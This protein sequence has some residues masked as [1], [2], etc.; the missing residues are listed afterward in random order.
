MQIGTMNRKLRPLVAS[1]A[2]ARLLEDE[3]AEAV[4]EAELACF[5]CERRKTLLQAELGQLA[6]AVRQE[7]DP[8]AERPDRGRGLEHLAGNAELVQRERER[9]SAHAA[10]DDEYVLHL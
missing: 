1:V 9:Q 7:I 2:P 8:H 10:A 6:H 5:H 3:L 4:V